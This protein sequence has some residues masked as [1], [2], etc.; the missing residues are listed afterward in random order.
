MRPT[1]RQLLIGG[2]VAS[3]ALGLTMGVYLRKPAAG[4]RILSEG[5]IDVVRALAEV[6]FPVG[7]PLGV[8][9]LQ[10]EVAER[11]DI[12]LEE[13]VD[14]MMAMSFRYLLRGIEWGSVGLSGSRF[15]R[16]TVSQR[17]SLMARW[18]VPG[19]WVGRTCGTSVK[20]VLGMAYFN[21]PQ[22]LE[23]VGWRLGCRLGSA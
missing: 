12:L 10:A 16:C 8:D 14:P 23:A 7:N 19:S 11:V 22:V 4:R 2:A 9:G 1:R 5:E 20:A 18:E 17:Q 15:S 13:T 6:M 21:H 3:T